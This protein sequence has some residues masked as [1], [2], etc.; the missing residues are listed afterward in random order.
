AAT[1]S[2]L[3]PVRLAPWIDSGRSASEN[4]TRIGSW[5]Q[6]AAAPSAGVIETTAG[7]TTSGSSP[8]HAVTAISETMMES[9]RNIRR[10]V[11]KTHARVSRCD[12]GGYAAGVRRSIDLD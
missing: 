11:R 4:T 12:N 10:P 2:P 6:I 8:P 5:S 7:G 3:G 9:E 1:G